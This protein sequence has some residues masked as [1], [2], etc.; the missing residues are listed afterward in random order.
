[1]LDAERFTELH[2]TH[3]DEKVLSVYLDTDQ[4]D[5]A[6]RDR[7][8]TALDNLVSI[9]RESAEDTTAFDRAVAHLGPALEPDSNQFMNGRGWAG[10]AT[11]DGVIHAGTVPTPMP[12][13][14]RWENGLHVAPY[15]RTRKQSRPVVAV[16]VDSRRARVLQYVQGGLSEADSLRADTYLGDLTDVNVAKRPAAH[17]GVRG[18]T[19]TDAAQRILEVERNRLLQRVAEEVID[20]AGETGFVVVGGN[21]R[22]MHALLERLDPLDETRVLAEPS[23]NFDMSGADV[24]SAV[25]AAASELSTRS[26]AETVDR[27]VDQAR[28]DGRGTLGPDDTERALRERRVDTLVVSRRLRQDRPDLA[29]RLG[30]AAFDQGAT[31]VEAARDAGAT[32][33]REGDGVGAILRYRIRG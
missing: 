8:R 29:D 16:I 30:G 18:K 7:W 14:V 6:E 19:G 2:R 25:E 24:R 22:A 1:M 10:F 33:D 31:V 15:V 9:A 17:S 21:E 11:P 5:F 26:Q 20:Q 28:A 23:L 13:L 12:D 32:L 3:R 27:L 4:A